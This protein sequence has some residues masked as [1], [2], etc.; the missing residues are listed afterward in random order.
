MAG[1]ADG[2]EELR[3]SVEPEI[4]D[5]LADGSAARAA[6]LP[7]APRQ[8]PA[9]TPPRGDAS[10]RPSVRLARGPRAAG[11]SSTSSPRPASARPT[12]VADY[13]RRSRLRT[14]WYRLD[15]DDTDGLVF[16]RYLVAA[17]RAVDTGLLGAVGR[18]ALR[19][20]ARADIGRTR[21]GDASRRNGRPRR[22]YRRRW[23]WTTSTWPSRCPPSAR[24]SSG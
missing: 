17:C 15:D 12:L 14:F 13:L 3:V 16:L 22:A 6:A 10:T 2:V 5:R 21:S 7:A 9:P 8:D 19:V 1:S 18:P 24:S 11:G 23:S 4:G 20:D